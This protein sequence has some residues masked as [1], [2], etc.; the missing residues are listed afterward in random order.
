[1]KTRKCGVNKHG[2]RRE[3]NI[4]VGRLLKMIGKTTLKQ[5]HFTI[6]VVMFEQFKMFPYYINRLFR[7]SIQSDDKLASQN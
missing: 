1:M 4:N 2:G 6:S 7:K 5:L 3:D